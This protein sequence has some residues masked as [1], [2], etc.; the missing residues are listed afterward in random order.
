MAM[1][2]SAEAPVSRRHVDQA[3]L[4]LLSAIPAVKAQGAGRVHTLPARPR[5]RDPK[6]LPDS[7]KRD[8]INDRAVTRA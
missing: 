7:T 8:R 6:F 5:K 3:Q 2:V 1:L 4:Y